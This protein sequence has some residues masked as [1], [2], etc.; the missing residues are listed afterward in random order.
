MCASLEE[1]MMTYEE[2][3]KY[4][5]GVSNFFCKPGLER[6]RE[7]CQGLGDPQKKLRFIHVTGTNGKGSVCSMLSSVL[8]EAGYKVG[9]FTSPYVLEFNERM[10]VNG[11]NIPNDTLAALTEKARAVAEK[12]TDRPTE[13]ELITAIAFEYFYEEGCDVVVLE[14]GMGGRYDATNIIDSS[15]LSVITGIS[16]DHTAFLGDTVEK[17]ASEKAGIIKPNSVTLYGGENLSAE[18]IIADEATKKQS[19]LC[20]TDYSRLKILSSDLSGTTFDYRSRAGLEISLLGSYQPKN[21]AIVL[22]ALDNLSGT[23][24]HVS[25]DAIRRGLKKASWPARFEIIGKE[26]LVI[27]DG[28]HN[29]QGIAAAMDSIKAYFGDRRVVIM[30][31][32]LRDKD[33]EAIADSLSEVAAEVYTITPDSPRALDAKEYADVIGVKGVTATPCLSV[34]EALALGKSKASDLNTAL[35][36]LGSLYTYGEVINA[37]K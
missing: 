2:A 36:C 1:K 24:L 4:I 21:A 15:L 16:I 17:I 12:M 31:G 26:P 3:I 14:V 5:H 22:D 8:Y 23:R 30:S 27:F 10:R 9:L 34:A 7:L 11:K 6:I 35:F 20:K 29:P 33:Y 19:I 25:E 18:A 32:V 28:A 13:F 37:L